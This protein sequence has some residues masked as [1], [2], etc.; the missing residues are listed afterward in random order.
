MKRFYLIIYFFLYV[1]M[2]FL[3][4]GSVVALEGGVLVK[5]EPPK[6]LIHLR[7]E[8][9]HGLVVLDE[10]HV[11]V[12]VSVR[13]GGGIVRDQVLKITISQ[14][15][16]G[17]YSITDEPFGAIPYKGIGGIAVSA[18]GNVVYV[19]D[20]VAA[21]IYEIDAKTGKL[22][23]AIETAGMPTDVVALGDGT[24]W[25]LTSDGRLHHYLQ[26]RRTKVILDREAGRPVA[27]EGARGLAVNSVTG[28]VVTGRG[29]VVVAV[30]AESGEVRDIAKGFSRVIDVSGVM[31]NGELSLFVADDEGVNEGG[32]VYIVK[33][34]GTK[35]EIFNDKKNDAMMPRYVKSFG[36]QR[37]IAIA[38]VV[39]GGNRNGGG[40]V[41][42]VIGKYG[43]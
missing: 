33:M 11:L 15:E 31:V 9:V 29:K 1:T 13:G 19:C 34:D 43:R 12:A 25:Y 18:D 22:R 32:K 20:R 36:S 2:N 26:G 21:R 37:Y 10:E 8:V 23:G 28:E 42:L 4:E 6:Q 30:D 17:G 16:N 14:D 40:R 3:I 5:T 38:S 7:C 24:L 39:K 35:R 27:I 41:V